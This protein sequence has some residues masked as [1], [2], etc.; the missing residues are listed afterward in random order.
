MRNRGIPEEGGT[1]RDEFY[2]ILADYE[3]RLDYA[4]KHTMLPDEPDYRAVEEFVMEVNEK[5]VRDE[6]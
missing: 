5:V 6:I 2:E 4:A 1:Y 3:K